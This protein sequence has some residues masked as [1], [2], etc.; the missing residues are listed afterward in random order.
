MATPEFYVDSYRS[1]MVRVAGRKDIVLAPR[2]I[3][4]EN[5]DKAA[6]YLRGIAKQLTQAF[7]D[8]DEAATVRILEEAEGKV[9]AAQLAEKFLEEVN[10]S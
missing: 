2:F 3:Q 9:R 10:F 4:N 6:D 8:G 7:A 1:L 5:Q